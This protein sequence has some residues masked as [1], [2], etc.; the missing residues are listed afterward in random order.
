MAKLPLTQDMGNLQ[1]LRSSI[2]PSLVDPVFVAICNKRRLTASDCQEGNRRDCSM[3]GN[4]T[5]GTE[6]GVQCVMMVV[7]MYV[8]LISYI[9]D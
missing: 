5:S 9:S 4:Q 6:G 3:S 7:R 8:C 1:T 2:L